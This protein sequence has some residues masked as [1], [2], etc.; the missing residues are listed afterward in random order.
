MASTLPSTLALSPSSAPLSPSGMGAAAAATAAAAAAA[1]SA[2]PAPTSSPGATAQASEQEAVGAGAGAAPLTLLPQQLPGTL[3]PPGAT[4]QRL[5]FLKACDRG[6]ATTGISLLSQDPTLAHI[7]DSHGRTPLH[8][9]ARSNCVALLREVQ[10]GGANMAC[11]DEG[12]RSPLLYAVRKGAVDAVEWLLRAGAPTSGPPDKHGLTP[13][14]HAVLAQ[15]PRCVRAL[16]AAGANVLARDMLGN[17]ALVLA[18]Q[19]ASPGPGSAGVSND[20]Q[21]EVLEC[22]QKAA[23]GGGG[24]G[25]P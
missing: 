1:A 9:S 5:E 22:L 21:W 11:V 12:G 6:D 10:L 2:A 8:F 14:H 19:V 3:I 13:L 7:R 20:R 4:T 23:G 15:S 16:L 18:A 24:G 17:N 25:R